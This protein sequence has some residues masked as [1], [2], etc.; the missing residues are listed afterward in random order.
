MVALK[1]MPDVLC[2]MGQATPETYPRV[3]VTGTNG[4]TTT[5]GFLA[6]GLKCLR[7]GEISHNALG[8]NMKTGITSLLLEKASFSG[9]LSGKGCV[10]ELDEASVYGVVKDFP[11]SGLV[12]T[13]LYRDQLDR[14]GEL[15]TTAQYIAKG[16]PYVREAL[17]LNADDPLVFALQR[18]A[19]A[20]QRIVT[21]SVRDE[22]PHGKLKDSMPCHPIPFPREGTEC[23]LCGTELT[24][25]THVYAQLGTYTCHGCGF[26]NTQAH[27]LMVT[28]TE[29][30]PETGTILTFTW[31]GIP[32]PTPY[33]LPMPG[34]FNVYNWAAACCVCLDHL[35][36]QHQDPVIAMRHFSPTALQPDVQVFGRAETLIQQGKNVKVFLI[37]NPV[38]AGEVLRWIAQ[39]PHVKL[40]VLLN[41][42]AADGKDVSWIWDT[43]FEWLTHPDSTLR[44]ASH[45]FVS[46]S[47]GED[48]ALRL[49]YAGYHPDQLVCLPSISQALHTALEATTSEECLVIVPTYTALLSL[50]ARFKKPLS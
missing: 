21:F 38:G 4:K 12:V 5:S 9:T 25:H 29:T 10:L 28:L 27:D 45:I 46:G 37:K 44:G 3:G 26:S 31:Q 16:F 34:C 1:W 2:H 17:Y 22:T 42:Q 24:F 8:A 48:M 36:Q 11:L 18:K 40:L 14:Y 49:Q 35:M 39:Q 30:N 32:Y 20:H 50:Q 23:P 41:D 6:Q 47:R 15:D 33:T 19:L 13:N 43:P 7:Q